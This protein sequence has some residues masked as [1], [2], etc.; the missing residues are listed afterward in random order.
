MKISF[1][2]ITTVYSLTFLLLIN[3][4]G[5]AQNSAFKILDAS[6]LQL[7]DTSERV[8]KIAEGFG[9]LEGPLWSK[10][11][12]LLVSDLRVNKI[13]KI[14]KDNKVDV[15]MERSGFTGTDTVGLSKDYGSNALAYNRQG[16]ILVCQH[17]NHAIALITKNGT[18]KTVVNS[19][20]GKRLNSPDDLAVKRDGSIYFTDPPYGFKNGDKD[21]HKA[22]EQNGIYRY[23]NDRLT[24]LSTDYRYPNGIAF[25]PDEKYLY[26]CS[27]DSKELMRR[28]EI[29]AD[30]TL[31]NGKIFSPIIGD[32][33]KVDSIGN[34]Y[35]CNWLG[36]HVFSPTGKEMGLIQLGEAVTNLNWGDEDHK[37]LYIVATSNIY[38][39]RIKF[40]GNKL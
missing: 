29:A 5:L 33:M 32:G 18:L 28:Y 19:Y 40:P 37:T 15:F 3:Q 1:K 38:K 23:K 35:L 9:F 10:K 36:V 12:Y 25:S 13:Y 30:G 14:G 27:Y 17:G 34:V 11:G 21:E 39:V 2:N 31:K 8:Q 24:I 16:N 22:Q 7:V 6:F 26:V 20:K 4:K